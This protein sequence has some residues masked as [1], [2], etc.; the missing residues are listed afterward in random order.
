M[1]L[2][3]ICRLKRRSQSLGFRSWMISSSL[4]MPARAWHGLELIDDVRRALEFCYACN[5]DQWSIHV[6]SASSRTNSE[7]ENILPVWHPSIYVC[8][9]SRKRES[10]YCTEVEKCTRAIPLIKNLLRFCERSAYFLRLGI[11]SWLDNYFTKISPGCTFC[12]QSIKGSKKVWP[13]LT[14]H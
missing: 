1:N 5:F 9:N 12:T 4:I 2:R 10:H 3:F 11:L 8:K 13:V 14:D 6:C 7:K